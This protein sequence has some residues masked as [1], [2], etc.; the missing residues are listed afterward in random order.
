M[1]KPDVALKFQFKMKQNQDFK[2]GH[3]R[4]RC[5]PRELFSLE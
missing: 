2:K 3:Y 1:M 5:V 4:S